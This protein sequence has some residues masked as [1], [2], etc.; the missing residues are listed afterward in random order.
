MAVNTTQNHVTRFCFQEPEF[1]LP[2]GI[3]LVGRQ[4]TRDATRLVPHVHAGAFELCFIASGEMGYQL[5]NRSTRIRAGEL[6]LCR[7]GVEH[8]GVNRRLTPSLLYWM[9]VQPEQL[10]PPGPERDFFDRAATG[11]CRLTRPDFWRAIF[12]E[13]LAECANR[14]PGWQEMLCNYV[15]LLLLELTREFS[16]EAP[17]RYSLPVRKVL[18]AMRE[19]PRGQRPLEE[20]LN[21]AGIG[22]S[23]LYVRFRAETGYSPHEYRLQQRIGAAQKLLETTREAVTA[24]AHACGFTS[25]QYFAVVFQRRT[26][27]T[28]SAW[29]RIKS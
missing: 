3:L 8:A 22:G 18:R 6:H 2:A 17:P 12:Q 20:L 26:G 28:P 14:T 10:L 7:P 16:A 9:E 23:A 1:L 29:R 25:S 15:R 11:K 4:D 21:H 24:I 13:M 27:Y 5:E 19:D